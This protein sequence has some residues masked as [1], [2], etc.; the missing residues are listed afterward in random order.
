MMTKLLHFLLQRTDHAQH[1]L[2][3]EG[4]RALTAQTTTPLPLATTEAA[5]AFGLEDEGAAR[6]EEAGMVIVL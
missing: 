5:G 6:G 3:R 4:N 1:D 2:G